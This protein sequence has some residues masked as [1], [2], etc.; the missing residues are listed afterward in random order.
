MPWTT[1][2]RP[3]SV[4]YSSM[5]GVSS[6]P[7]MSKTVRLG[8]Q[9]AMAASRKFQSTCRVASKGISPTNAEIKDSNW[10]AGRLKDYCWSRVGGWR[11]AP[12]ECMVLVLRGPYYQKKQAGTSSNPL[13]IPSGV[14]KLCAPVFRLVGTR[15][16]A[17][18]CNAAWECPPS[19]GRA[20]DAREKESPLAI[21][22]PEGRGPAS[23]WDT[24]PRDRVLK[25]RARSA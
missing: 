2:V 11:G 20:T 14:A 10:R 9:N 16:C 4:R 25:D 12:A 18:K 6:V 22:R 21:L 8:F 13:T 3:M 23:V 1:A 17:P 15:M 7:C 19:Q 24:R 5:V